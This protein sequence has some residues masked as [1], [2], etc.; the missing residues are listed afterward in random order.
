LILTLFRTIKSIAFVAIL[1]PVVTSH[2]ET[3]TTVSFHGQIIEEYDISAVAYSKGLLLLGSD[4]ATGKKSNENYIQLLKHEG[5]QDY[6]LLSNI[7][8]YR[9]SKSLGR[10]LDIEG[11]ATEGESLYVI[12]SH[13]LA[14][15]RLKK[16][17]SYE[18]NLARLGQ[19]KHE[20]SRSSLYRLSLNASFQV[21]R[22]EH[23]QLSSILNNDPVLSHF[24]GIPGKENGIDIEGIAVKDRQLYIGFR[25]PVLRGGYVPVLQLPFD[26]PEQNYQRLH[27]KLEGRGIRDIT[28]VSDGF[29]VLAGP[30][31]DEAL[32]YRLLHW[33]GKDCIPGKERS[34]AGK[35]KLL[36]EI[37]PPVGGKA[38]GV[39][40]I[41]ET[42]T[43]YNLIVVF[44]GVKKGAPRH[45][46][47]AKARL[48]SGLQ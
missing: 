31:G 14:R 16:K 36:T 18:K 17:F 9:G 8:I 5:K 29:L 43:K 30:V 32:S 34:D 40:V 35:L 1:S 47:I 2:A 39:S 46:T 21:I 15:K 22:R 10:E 24:T 27:L 13:S 28:A 19:I 20:P 41:S 37:T 25:G 38:E 48:G 33:N 42:T 11:I 45:Y 26:K 4:E 23:I 44:D 7:L 12:G 6:S 3:M